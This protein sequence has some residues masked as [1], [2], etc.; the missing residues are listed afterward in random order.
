MA[1]FKNEYCMH[2]HTCGELRAA[3]VD[4]QVVLTGWV[5]HN[6]DHGGLIFVD[7]RDRDG[8]T[9]CVFDP[10]CVTADE[11]HIAEHLG[12]EFVIEVKGT[13]RA[14]GEGSVNPNMAT[15]EIEV[16]ANA[17]KVLN[18][19]VTPPFSIEDGIETDETTRMKWRYM[20]LRRPEMY[21][22]LLLR[23]TVAQ[24]MRSALNARGFLEVETPI[25]ANSTPEGAR[26]YIVPS[27]P[28]PGKFYALPQSPQQFKQML[29]CGGIER[30]YQIARC[31]RDE[32]LRADRQPEF[33]QVDIEM[34]FVNRDDVLQMMEDVMAEVLAAVGVEHEFPLQ[35]MPWKE[36]MDRFGCDRPDTRFG[37]ELV[38][39]TDIVRGCG[40][41]VFSK[42]VEA[43]NIVK[44]IN[45]KGAGDWSRGDIEKLA[46]VAAANGAKGM[47]W[48]AYTTDGKEKSPI[49][50]FLGEEVH[51][52]IKKAMNVEPGDLLLFAAD[53]FAIA[54][55]VLAALRLHMADLLGIDRSGHALLWVVD[56]PMFNYDPEEKKYAAEHHPFTMVP[57]ED[58]EKIE[59]APLEVGS[60]SYDLVMDGFEAGG[61]TIRVHNAELQKRILRRVG[62]SEEDLEV[63]FGHLLHAL[64]LGAPPHGGIAL[65]LDRLCML[66]AGKD[67]IRDVIAF[68]K[69]SSAA[70]PMTGAPNV[71]SGRQL[72][73]VNLRIL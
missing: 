11:F 69:T 27:R 5:W 34:S 53:T 28:N 3:D 68:P 48:I 62:V 57:E 26:D 16:L 72:K 65:G 58:I 31:F 46:D 61:G 52:A 40:F 17:I 1:D 6:R 29:M 50:K 60:Y 45:A 55:A 10:D 30:Y 4:A 8:Y 19:S 63:K 64:E 39:L 2:T 25:L 47:A 7:L 20:D 18:T 37:M 70:D 67:S 44:A 42:A 35:R 41:G 66:L 22:S 32:D 9:Q 71:V 23:H 56:F 12:R 36:A 13:V 38:E 59:T 51:E 33:T 15:G 73:E 14:R 49:I 21:K 43:G 24:A 54:N